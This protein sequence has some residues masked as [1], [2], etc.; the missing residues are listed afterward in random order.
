MNTFDMNGNVREFVEQI[1][2]IGPY[3]GRVARGG[4]FT[5]SV[6]RDYGAYYRENGLYVNLIVSIDPDDPSY[7]P[8]EVY[9]DQGLG[10]RVGWRP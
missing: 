3:C 4:D 10:F 9:V 7:D 1:V 6:Y 2:C 8:G 5:S